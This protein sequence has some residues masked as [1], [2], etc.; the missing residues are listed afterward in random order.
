MNLIIVKNFNE[1][2]YYEGRSIPRE[3]EKQRKREEEGGGG[4]EREKERS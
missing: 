2:A 1:E 3:K 4:E